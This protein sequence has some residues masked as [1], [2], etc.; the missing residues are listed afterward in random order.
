MGK[1][2]R[3]LRFLIWMTCFVAASVTYADWN[4]DH[5]TYPAPDVRAAGMSGAF[6]GLATGPTAIFWNPA[7]LAELGFPTVS[8]EWYLN[9]RSSGSI[10][11]AT[12]LSHTASAGISWVRRNDVPDLMGEPSSLDRL[13][14]A[15]GTTLGNTFTV[16]VG[17]TYVNPHFRATAADSGGDGMGVDINAGLNISLAEQLRISFV[18]C[19]LIDTKVHRSGDAIQELSTRTFRTGVAWQPGERFAVAYQHDRADRLGAEWFFSST[20]GFRAGAGYD[21]EDWDWAL[22]ASLRTG[23]IRIDYAYQRLPGK[24]VFHRLGME[25]S[26][27]QGRNVLQMSRPQ[28]RP[29]Y[30]SLSKTYARQPVGS[31]VLVNSTSVAVRTRVQLDIPHHAA[32]PLSQDVTVRPFSR[33]R[34]FLHT[35]L[36][37]T[38]SR[39]RDD[40]PILGVISLVDPE[41]GEVTRKRSVQSY[42][43]R[44]G[45]LTWDDTRKAAAFVTPA[46]PAVRRFVS[47]AIRPYRNGFVRMPPGQATMRTAALLFEAAASWGITYQV[48][49][50]T[51]YAQ[52]HSARS[53]L[54]MLGAIGSSTLDIALSPVKLTRDVATTTLGVAKDVTV[55]T[56]NVVAAPVRTVISRDSTATDSTRGVVRQQTLDDTATVSARDTLL[57]NT[58]VDT[59]ARAVAGV[60]NTVGYGSLGI[61]DSTTSA[62]SGIFGSLGAIG[63]ESLQFLLY[64]Y[65]SVV[66]PEAREMV[67][68]D[69]QYPV[70]LL[71]TRA[72]DCDDSSVFMCTL[73]ECA[74]ISTAFLESPE[75]IFMMFDTGFSTDEPP[76]SLPG[77][78]SLF[79]A[80]EGTYWI[81]V[82]TTML[83]Y[84]FV[85]AWENAAATLRNLTTDGTLPATRIADA[86]TTYEPMEQVA[87]DTL[88]AP[89]PD[90]TA[91]HERFTRTGSAL[92]TLWEKSRTV[93]ELTAEVQT[94]PGDHAKR[95]QL[96]Y[97]L[98]YSNRV[99]D[100]E[101]HLTFLERAEY[102]PARVKG[103]RA[104]AWYLRGD[105]ARA[106]TTAQE[107][108]DLAPWVLELQTLLE[109]IHTIREETGI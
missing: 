18:V 86:W 13:D 57:S 89:V 91:L 4:V 93:V 76:Y 69:I 14:A 36:N 106:E 60:V 105:L 3:K 26:F 25:M 40:L 84:G 21:G 88:F 97:W 53:P 50:N 41:T 80:Y 20:V 100:A 6:L 31:V 78:D 73:M 94:T 70:G 65:Q 39:V 59:T 64:P 67:V 51:P 42:L 23:T 58:L 83:Q 101:E 52:V 99:D 55:G 68:D 28:L 87:A 35:V 102:E 61:V 46:D 77:P 8:G 38:S 66:N 56:A 82:E 11:F 45:A 1:P 27:P 2:Y 49:P 85:A 9:S 90:T 72:G 33:K 48:D 96:V 44:S 19:D 104:V 30:A 5:P 109:Q 32:A 62:V 34:V 22:G 15:L 74:G 7:G 98:L 63:E 75:H 103:L 95:A 92:N 79:F 54:A 16:G 107:A 47:E 108:L 43:Y 12:P 24:T 17:M 71:S 29:L 81:P 10:Y 37:P